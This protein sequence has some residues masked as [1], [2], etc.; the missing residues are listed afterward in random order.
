MAPSGCNT[1]D[2]VPS[3]TSDSHRAGH[4]RLDGV[5]SLVKALHVYGDD[6]GLLLL[7]ENALRF[8]SPLFLLAVKGIVLFSPLLYFDRSDVCCGP[9][10]RL[11][12]RTQ[13]HMQA[14]C[15]LSTSSS[16]LLP[17]IEKR[18]P[19]LVC[20]LTTSGPASESNL[21]RLVDS[22]DN[23]SYALH[24]EELGVCGIILNR[25]ST[26]YV[27]ALCV[28]LRAVRCIRSSALTG[29]NS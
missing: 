4:F 6:M 2:S 13:L 12:G 29:P 18:T 28:S 16:S 20:G 15:F 14:C 26:E 24:H 5:S 9:P 10:P 8:P 7:V 11:S 25:H 21:N 23:L 27:S 1:S 17:D 22:E 3:G 19:F